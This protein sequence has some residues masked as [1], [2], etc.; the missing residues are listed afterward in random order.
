[1]AVTL[2]DLLRDK[3]IMGVVNRI[4]T[5]LSLF[6]NYLGMGVG[7]SPMIQAQSRQI[8]WD[9]F[10][11]TRTVASGSAPGTG[12][13]RVTRKSIGQGYAACMRMHESLLML[14]EEIFR[15]RPVGAPVGTVDQN[16]QAYIARQINYMTQRVKNIREFM[17]SRMFYGGF[18]LD[19]DGQVYRPVEAGSGDIQI[20]TQT[21]AAHFAQLALG[22]AAADLITASWDNANTDI[23]KQLNNVNAAMSRIYGAPLR[24]VWINTG[25]YNHLLNN[26]KLQ[27]QGGSVMRPF[28]KLSARDIKS[29]E[30]IPDTGFDVVFRACPL[31]TFHV[32]DGVLNLNDATGNSTSADD[33][34]MI[35]KN[36]TA[37]MHPDKG[38]WCGWAAGAE[39]F[40]RN[41]AQQTS[42]V[43]QGFGAWATP[44]IDPAGHELKFIDNGLPILSVPK[45][46]MTPT[47]VFGG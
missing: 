23:A 13:T 19:V 31:F 4:A 26:S 9:I 17:V 35:V 10:D 40:R 3:S 44:T 21:P 25:V 43:V 29:V 15:T 5:P 7:S 12:P 22:A 28:D 33:V 38:D 39:P 45:A 41:L 2:G 32:Y 36:N 27:S 8:V 47:V 20:R 46:I 24:H 11:S 14:D 34:T 37:I 16:G 18:D 30:G 1:M 6:Q 42:S